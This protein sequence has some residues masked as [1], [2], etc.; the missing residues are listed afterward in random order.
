MLAI[1]LGVLRLSPESFWR[2]TPRELAAAMRGLF[3]ESE[4]PL[5]RNTLEQL[6]PPLSGSTQEPAE[7]ISMTTIDGITVSI[8]AD[9]SAFQREIAAADKL[10]KGFGASIDAALSGAIVYGRNFDDVPIATRF[11]PVL[12]CRSARLSSRSSRV[13]SVASNP[14]SP[15]R[16]RVATAAARH[17]AFR[18]RRSD[19]DA[20]LFPHGIEHR[21][22]RGARRRSDHAARARRGRETRRGRANVG[23]AIRHP[24]RI[25]AGC[26]ELPALGILSGP[27]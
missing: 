11:A 23:A 10:A 18:K 20:Q 6:C 1:G 14:C 19:F 21:P 7:E 27:A 2:M 3:G 26:R 8:A 24:E 9:T 16:T 15:I 17:Q 25:D 13:C 5:D 4:A 12:A 22:C